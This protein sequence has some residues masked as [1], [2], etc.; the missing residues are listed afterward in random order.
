MA[1]AIY[2]TDADY[3]VMRYGV[4]RSEDRASIRRRLESTARSHGLI[5]SEMYDRAVQRF[6]SF[7]FER[8]ERKLDALKRKVSHL[9]DTDEVRMM[10][11]I[12][13]F[14]QAG[15]VLQR[16]I[17]ANPRAKRLHEKDMIHG[18]KSSGYVPNYPGRYGHDDPDYQQVMHG[19]HYTDEEG[20][21]VFTNYLH[22]VDDDGRTELTF[23]AQTTIRDSIWANFEAHL[24]AGM[25]DPTSPDNGSL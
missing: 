19:L 8:I 10:H 17:M 23:G 11:D 14:Q 22:I 4:P 5:G 2:A 16:W 18:Y 21:D 20:N 3:S 24:D 7:N 25:D 15:P 9:F 12:G 13:D 1:V 6:D